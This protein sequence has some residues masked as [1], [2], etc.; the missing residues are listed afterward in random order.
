MKDFFVINL[1]GEKEPFSFQKVMMS[2]KRAGASGR[3]AEKIAKEIQRKAFPGMRTSEIYK[4]VRRLL[5]EAEPVAAIKFDLKEA[6]KKLGPAGFTFEKF[7]GRVLESEGFKIDLNRYI[8]GK[9]CSEYEIDFLASKGSILYVGECKY[10]T[11]FAGK[12]DL[13]EA[14]Q[15][16]ARFIDIKSGS[17]LSKDPGHL[18]SVLVTNAKFTSKAVKYS[19]CAGVELLGW[20]YPREASLEKRIE[21]NSLYPITI[22]PSLK[23]YLADIF[24]E[25]GILTVRDLLEK[26]AEA[27]LGKKIISQQNFKTLV[28]EA[29]ILL[30]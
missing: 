3:L 8:P 26:D 10:R 24:I 15:N 7:I 18:K 4:T 5:K 2:A 11:Q 28:K 6:M 12:V 29:E 13:P 9:C 16:Y 23:N 25:K 30:K 27:L 21:R 14:L 20:K 19:K 17:F 1:S 22:L